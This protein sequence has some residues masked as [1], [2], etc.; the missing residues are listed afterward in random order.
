MY[1]RRFMKI[2]SS[3][4]TLFRFFIQYIWCPHPISPNLKCNLVHHD[5]IFCFY[6]NPISF[7]YKVNVW[8]E[9]LFKNIIFHPSFLFRRN[10]VSFSD[11]C[12]WNCISLEASINKRMY[13]FIVFLCLRIHFF[14]FPYLVTIFP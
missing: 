5:K 8:D 4:Q 1:P 7:P 2:A 13:K 3:K 11:N 9:C 14:M 6:K 10:F 12:V